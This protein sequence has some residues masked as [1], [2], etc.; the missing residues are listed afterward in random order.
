MS[1]TADSHAGQHELEVAAPVVWHDAQGVGG[2]DAAEPAH[3]HADVVD[4]EVL[5][6]GSGGLGAVDQ[7]VGRGRSAIVGR[8]CSSASCVIA[9]IM[10]C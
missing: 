8:A 6:D 1:W 7:A 10:R 2:H 9:K 4:D 5:A 3:E